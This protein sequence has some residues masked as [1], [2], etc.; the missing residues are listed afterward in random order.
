MSVTLMRRSFAAAARAFARRSAK[1]AM[2]ATGFSGFCGLTTHQTSSRPRRWM[3]AREMSRCPPWAGLKDPPRMP[4]RRAM[5]AFTT[6]VWWTQYSVRG[7]EHEP[8][9]RHNRP[10]L[11][12]SGQPGRHRPYPA[13]EPIRSLGPGPEADRARAFV[14]RGRHVL[15]EFQDLRLCA[16]P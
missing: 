10:A 11:L 16:A 6:L 7:D 1:G 4:M 2:P 3:A 15:P 14:A 8:A 5:P 9:H 13:G 12:Y